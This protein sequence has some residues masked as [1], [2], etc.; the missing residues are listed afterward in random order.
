MLRLFAII[1]AVCVPL[2]ISAN[3]AWA[4]GPPS[5]GAEGMPGALGTFAF[6]PTDWAEGKLTW[7]KDT[8]G[9]N[10]GEAGCHIGTDADGKPDGRL[11]GEA[12][13]EGG[14]NLVESNPEANVSHSHANDDQSR[15]WGTDD[16]RRRERNG[17]RVVSFFGLA[18]LVVC[19]HG[20]LPRW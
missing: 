18:H 4:D 3:S 20:C 9:V 16:R 5:R 8:D 2:M 7:W 11:F 6:K 15:R 13:L 19:I 1:L 14:V 17:R 12:C 10:P